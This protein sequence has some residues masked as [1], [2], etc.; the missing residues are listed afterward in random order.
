MNT[1]CVPSERTAN[2]QGVLRSDTPQVCQVAAFG[3][4]AERW[5]A[6]LSSDV[7]IVL[8]DETKCAEAL[9]EATQKRREGMLLTAPMLDVSRAVVARRLAPLILEEKRDS[10]ETRTMFDALA[11]NSLVLNQTVQ[12]DVCVVDER[13]K[14]TLRALYLVGSATLVRSRRQAALLG[15]VFGRYRPDFVV[16]PGYD[17]DVPPH[18]PLEKGGSIVIWAPH[19]GIAALSVYLFA[20]ENLKSPVVVICGGDAGRFVNVRVASLAEA[21]RELRQAALI[22]D[23][24]LSDPATAVALAAWRIPLV[25]ASSS[26][27]DEFVP[28]VRL[29]DPWSW[30]SILAAVSAGRADA[31]SIAAPMSGKISALA[32]PVSAQSSSPGECGPLVTIVVPT[33]DRA[34]VLPQALDSVQAQS[35]QNIEVLVVN[36]G[37]PPIDALVAR[38]PRARCISSPSNRGVLASCNIGIANASGS[39]IGFLSDDDIY[40]FDH[41]ERLVKALEQSGAYVAHAN[42]LTRFLEVD[43]DGILKTIG[44]HVLFAAHLDTTE[45]LWWGYLGCNLVRRDVFDRIGTYDVTNVVADYEMFVRLSRSFDFVHVDHVTFEWRYRTDRATLTHNVGNAAII[46]GLL[47]IFERYPSNGDAR[48]EAGRAA[49]LEFVNDHERMPYWEPPLRL[50]PGQTDRHGHF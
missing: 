47:R 12:R 41:V 35:Y 11:A 8:A 10:N 17:R 31:P 20:L 39:Y 30:R 19:E 21:P 27:A 37:G 24:S 45:A 33:Y 50:V 3:S 5:A 32:A 26:G 25:A 46:E 4:E 2:A 40:Y 36:D 15:T 13:I 1:S 6:R 49:T 22:I 42:S 28:G 16:R 14:Q 38:Y 29:Y 48:V 23:G 43:G 9:E 34:D 18:E 44:S 7:P